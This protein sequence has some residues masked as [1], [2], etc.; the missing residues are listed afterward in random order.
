MNKLLLL[1]FLD[2]LETRNFNRTADRLNITQ[3]TVSARVRMLE[4]DLGARLFERGR[5]GAEPTPAGRRFEAHCRSLL[6]TWGQAVKDA[7]VGNSFTESLKISAQ[8]SL[9]RSVILEWSKK[10]RT[11]MPSVSM[12]FEL[13]YSMQVMRDISSGTADIGIIFSPQ[14]LSDMTIESIGKEHF[15]MVSNTISKLSDVRMEHYFKI[16]YTPSFEKKHD[17]LLPHLTR[18]QLSAGNDDLAMEFLNLYGGTTYVPLHVGNRLTR[19]DTTYRLV[20]G[21]PIISQDV[22][23]VVHFRKRHSPTVKKAISTLKE[24]FRQ[25]QP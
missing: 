4:D 17:E 2:I 11:A 23:A 5:G 19:D 24:E 21:A 3:S 15:V 7:S 22:F 13:D 25:H 10:L 6:N 18:T 8:P 12:H 16:G 9:I 20:E 14:Y 1:T